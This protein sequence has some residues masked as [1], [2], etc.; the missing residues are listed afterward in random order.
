MMSGG[1]RTGWPVVRNITCI[2]I[3][4]LAFLTA[5]VAVLVYGRVEAEFTARTAELARQAALSTAARI[6]KALDAAQADAL[7]LLELN[8]GR[9]RGDGALRARQAENERF[10]KL[11][12]MFAAILSSSGERLENRAFFLEHDL[13][14]NSPGLYLGAERELVERAAVME[15]PDAVLLGNA[16]PYFGAPVIALFFRARNSVFAAF[17]SAD[18]FMPLLEV[19]AERVFV[20]NHRD[21]IILHTDAGVVMSG[22]NYWQDPLVRL[23]RNSAVAEAVFDADDGG[24]GAFQKLRTAGADAAM[25]FE[26]IAAEFCDSQ[27]LF[28]S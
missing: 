14:E 12:P 8:G 17:F 21:D 24:P 11:R 4:F 16:S 9:L 2:N 28:E 13:D 10:F 25:C 3:V 19:G 18:A 1:R 20:V 7:T 5:V 23:M 22:E 26:H 6:E 15:G 27:K